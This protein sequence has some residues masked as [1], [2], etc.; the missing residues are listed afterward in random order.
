MYRSRNLPILLAGLLFAQT[1]VVGWQHRHLDSHDVVGGHDIASIHAPCEHSHHHPHDSAP[2]LPVDEHDCSICH[3][4]AL[5]AI[6]V[7]PC[8]ANACGE[9]VVSI[10]QYE[11]ALDSREVSGLYRPR[12]PPASA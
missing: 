4:L 12:S 2:R 7:V 1:L 11:P 5:A 10:C 3:H 8:D 6:L 9:A